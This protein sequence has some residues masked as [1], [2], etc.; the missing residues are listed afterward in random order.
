[1]PGVKGSSLKRDVVDI[2][3]R[4]DCEVVNVVGANKGQGNIL[5]MNNGEVEAGPVRRDTKDNRS[6]MVVVDFDYTRFNIGM[7]A[8]GDNLILI[9]RN[10]ISSD[11]LDGRET[12]L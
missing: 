8:I 5:R 3:L 12:S 10:Y 2:V 1:V 4:R 7:V 11:R 9:T 6:N